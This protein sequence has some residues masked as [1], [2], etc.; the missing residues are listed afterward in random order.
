MALGL[1]HTAQQMDQPQLFS[2]EACLAMNPAQPALAILL[3][4]IVGHALLALVIIIL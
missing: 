3:A 2:V 1:P 4:C